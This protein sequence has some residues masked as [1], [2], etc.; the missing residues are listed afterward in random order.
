MKGFGGEAVEVPLGVVGQEQV[1][2]LHGGCAEGELHSGTVQSGE[3]GTPQGQ[4]CRPTDLGLSLPD[5]ENQYDCLSIQ[6]FTHSNCHTASF[7]PVSKTPY[8]GCAS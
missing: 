3:T 4:L 5:W 2:F 1:T 6:L 8:R 7:S